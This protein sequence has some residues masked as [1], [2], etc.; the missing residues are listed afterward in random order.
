M[1]KRFCER[2]DFNQEKTDSAKESAKKLIKIVRE[3]GITTGQKLLTWLVEYKLG[4]KTDMQSH[5]QKLFD[6]CDS[7]PEYWLQEVNNTIDLYL[8]TKK[9]IATIEKFLGENAENA[10]DETLLPVI[11]SLIAMLSKRDANEENTLQIWTLALRS[12]ST[13]DVKQLIESQI[14]E[15]MIDAF[16]SSDERI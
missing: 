10:Q 7:K 5:K 8:G 1:T 2:F 15:Q 14:L 13:I 12:L 9:L 11:K 3:Q 16:L 6:L 4:V